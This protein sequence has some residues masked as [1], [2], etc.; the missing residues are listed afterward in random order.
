MKIKG[1]DENKMFYEYI[2]FIANIQ[3]HI[4][5]LSKKY[6]AISDKLKG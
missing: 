4:D 6:K 1:S 5:P 2:N 3:K